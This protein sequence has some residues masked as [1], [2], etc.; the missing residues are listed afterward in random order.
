MASKWLFLSCHLLPETIFSVC[1]VLMAQGPAWLLCSGPGATIA[2]VTALSHYCPEGL[3][4]RICKMRGH[5]PHHLRDSLQ[6]RT[7]SCAEVGQGQR[8]INPP[9]QEAASLKGA[10]SVFSGTNTIICLQRREGPGQLKP[11]PGTRGSGSTPHTQPPGRREG[12]AL[13]PGT[14]LGEAQG[15][16]RGEPVPCSPAQ[17][18]QPYLLGAGGGSAGPCHVMGAGLPGAPCRRTNYCQ[19]ARAAA[20]KGPQAHSG[21]PSLAPQEGQGGG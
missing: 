1:S 3:S 14:L 17:G 15:L 21:T 16:L 9:R 8:V 6:L 4:L 2:L 13:C 19:R 11:Q 5:G 18:A 12:G 7:C 10:T 20:G